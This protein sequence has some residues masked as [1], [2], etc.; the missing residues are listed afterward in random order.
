MEDRLGRHFVAAGG[1]WRRLELLAGN[2]AFQPFPVAPA[3]QPIGLKT[4]IFGAVYCRLA[5]GSLELPFLAI[6]VKVDDVA[7]L[8]R[9][10]ESVT[11]LAH[12]PIARTCMQLAN[13]NYNI[14]DRRSAFQFGAVEFQVNTNR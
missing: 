8:A 4:A 13:T 2:L 14:F 5:P 9:T 12:Q 11:S 3:G 10:L 6:L 7:H 1:Q